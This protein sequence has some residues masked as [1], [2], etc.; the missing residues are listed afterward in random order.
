MISLPK[1][2]QIVAELRAE[3]AEAERLELY[4]AFKAEERR[5]AS[6]GEQLSKAQDEKFALQLEVA[7]LKDRERARKR[8]ARKAKP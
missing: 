8:A 3:I 4:D 5:A 1:A 7:V 6:C 2:R